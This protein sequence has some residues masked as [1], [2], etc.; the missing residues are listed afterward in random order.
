MSY[1]AGSLGKKNMIHII[2]ATATLILQFLDLSSFSS[3]ESSITLDSCSLVWNRIMWQVLPPKSSQGF[4]TSPNPG[5]EVHQPMAV[6]RYLDP[7]EEPPPTD[8]MENSVCIFPEGFTVQL[9]V[10]LKMWRI[11]YRRQSQELV[12][13]NLFFL[14]KVQRW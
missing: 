14:Q 6:H 10:W 4:G 12:A 2:Y 5:R 7:T 13:P 11:K 8:S 9:M 3:K 1:G